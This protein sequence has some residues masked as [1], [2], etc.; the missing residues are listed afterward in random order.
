MASLPAEVQDD[1]PTIEECFDGI[2]RV[3]AEIARHQEAITNLRAT[4]EGYAFFLLEAAKEQGE[5]EGS[6]YR[7][8]LVKGR[9]SISWDHTKAYDECPAE[10]KPAL[11]TLT[12]KLDTKAA[13]ALLEKLPEAM[14][15]ARTVNEGVDRY[16]VEAAK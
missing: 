11:F 13:N 6:G 7:V 2:A 16:E 4:R 5:M 14:L 3:D 12:P 15:A 1:T 8:R 10:L 9:K